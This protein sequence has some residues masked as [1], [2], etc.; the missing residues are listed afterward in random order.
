M[1]G[2]MDWVERALPVAHEDAAQ[3]EGYM[4]TDPRAAAFYARRCVERVV[5]FVYATHRL[6]DP[7]KTDGRVRWSV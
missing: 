7:Y 4:S 5:E 1:A 6:E 3:A 2:N